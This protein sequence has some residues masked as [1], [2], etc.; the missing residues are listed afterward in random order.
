MYN[1]DLMGIRYTISAEGSVLNA[2]IA[3]NNIISFENNLPQIDIYQA[4][5]AEAYGN[6]EKY[7][8][9][10][11]KTARTKELQ[12]GIAFLEDA[13]MEYFRETAPLL[14]KA[15][16]PN[17]HDIREF[18]ANV[19]EPIRINKIAQGVDA[20][21]GYTIQ[22]ADES[23]RAVTRSARN[24]LILVVA[25][26]ILGLI[27]SITLAIFII[28]S[29]TKPVRKVLQALLGGTREITS[30]SQQLAS[31]SQSIASGSQEQAASVEETSASLEKLASMVKNTLVNTKE[32]SNLAQ[33]ASENSSQGLDKM[34]AMIQAM[35]AISKSTDEINAVIDVI[36]DIAFQTNML[37]LNAAVEAARAGE[38]GL[39]F[40][41]V[42]DEVKSLANRSSESAKETAHM[43]K[44]SLH[45]V[46]IGRNLSFE[47]A[48]MFKD[49]AEQNK[50]VY[51]INKEIETSSSQQ[52]EG[53]SQASTAMLQLDTV[54]QTNAA[55]AEET[56]S[57]SEELNGQA[58][59][60]ATVVS[61]LEKVVY[62][63]VGGKDQIKT[64]KTEEKIVQK[65]SVAKK[66]AITEKPTTAKAKTQAE[67]ETKQKTEIKNKS[68]EKPKPEPK[69]ETIKHEE[70]K[71]AVNPDSIKTKHI[72]SFEDDE[73]YKAN[74]QEE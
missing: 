32:A 53:I 13:M 25:L 20:L 15:R 36:D 47:I 41:V 1:R 45:N 30:S 43:I 68:L 50:K 48:Q 63:D 11:Q 57:A 70:K 54:V 38:A 51:E 33:I 71:E 67:G 10:L 9:E 8:G 56:A 27:I 29:I 58:L 21:I 28:R 2:A 6:F 66:I 52:N 4:E 3:V 55:E 73:E 34:Q 35:E 39:G 62:G 61:S 65:T 46:E 19:L 26:L 24:S 37:A 49:M 64:K 31:T 44:E 12:E 42:A 18:N 23:Y 40:A 7:M 22:L 69:A 5:L 17:A 72:I 14:E 59:S 74:P 16:D 60:I